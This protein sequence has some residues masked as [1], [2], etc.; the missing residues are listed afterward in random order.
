MTGNFRTIE[1]NYLKDV[2]CAALAWEKMEQKILKCSWRELLGGEEKLIGGKL[3][4][5]Q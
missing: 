4:R 3:L 2:Y 5:K 1:E